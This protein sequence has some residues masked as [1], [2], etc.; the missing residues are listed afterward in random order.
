MKQLIK[1]NPMR[2]SLSLI[3]IISIMSCSSLSPYKVPILQ[4]NIFEEKDIEKLTEGL[5]K[6]QVQF[7]FGTSLIKD[8]FHSSRWDYYYSIRVGNELLDESKLSIFFNEAE[9]VDSWIIENIK[10]AD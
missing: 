3:A 2:I 6:E 9:L 7:I 5:T 10:E 4:G 8:P 1:F